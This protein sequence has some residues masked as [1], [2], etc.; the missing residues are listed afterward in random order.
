MNDTT[1]EKTAAAD[2]PNTPPMT[3]PG[4]ASDIAP[5]A[6][7]EV[8]DEEVSDEAP[9]EESSGIPYHQN[10]LDREAEKRRIVLRRLLTWSVLDLVTLQAELGISRQ[11]TLRTLAGMIRDHQIAS[12]AVTPVRVRVYHLLPAG[13]ELARIIAEDAGDELAARTGAVVH[14]SRIN[15]SKLAHNLIV[16]R[17]AMAVATDDIIR[18][19]EKQL[20]FGKHLIG[21]DVHNRG[22]SVPDAL[23]IDPAD[24]RTW[25]LEVQQSRQEPAV[26]ER[27]V[28][29]YLDAITR[30][31]VHGVIWCSTRQVILDGIEAA[32]VEGVR[33]WIFHDTQ[34]RWYPDRVKVDRR[35]LDQDPFI[36]RVLFHPVVDWHD[37]YY[38][39]ILRR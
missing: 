21:G 2:D 18:R 32:T 26:Y 23:L 29:Q 6:T 22:A 9:A 36:G 19:S 1:N 33:R 35:L 31:E 14:E 20:Y 15:M 11:A 39:R 12:L 7:Y 8:A 5:T 28:A 30:G 34:R 38:H 24:N 16:A 13:L 27:R 4:D 25:A 10:S 37:D 17:Y 3:A